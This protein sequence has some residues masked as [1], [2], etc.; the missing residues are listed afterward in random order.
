[1]NN[2]KHKSQIGLMSMFSP[3]DEVSNQIKTYEEKMRRAS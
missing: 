1:M 3:D 2:A